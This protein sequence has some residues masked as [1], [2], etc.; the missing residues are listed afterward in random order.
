MDTQLQADAMPAPRPVTG[1]TA[2]AAADRTN[3]RSSLLGE[4]ARAM[5]AAAERERKRIDAGIGQE[6][7]VQVEKIRTRAGAEAAAL[8]KGADDDVELVNLWCLEETRRIREA[9]DRRIQERRARLD[10]AVTEHGSLIE[11]EIQSVHVAVQDYRDTLGTFF[12]QLADE[13]D[14]SAIARLAGTLPEPP[15]LDST[16]SAARS[17]AMQALAA[18]SGGAPRRGR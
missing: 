14:P 8:R 3:P 12:G 4:I 15:D 18:E 9:A 17:K 13:P 7:T 5:Q 16:R 2:S 6:E 1:R 11:A 10:Q